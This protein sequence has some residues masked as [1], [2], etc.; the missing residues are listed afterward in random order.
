[1]GLRPRTLI[2]LFLFLSPVD[3]GQ[4]CVKLDPQHCVEKS[5]DLKKDN[6]DELSVL[7]DVALNHVV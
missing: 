5:V 6:V 1:M 4:V 2:L 7:I 3:C